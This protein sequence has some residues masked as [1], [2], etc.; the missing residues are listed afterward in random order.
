[1]PG[2]LELEIALRKV[3][4]LGPFAGNV[5]RRSAIP[6]DRLL[7]QGSMAINSQTQW[8]NR[9]AKTQPQKFSLYRYRN[10]KSDPRTG[11]D[12]HSLLVT[13]P[14]L[15]T[16]CS[17]DMSPQGRYFG[18]PSRRNIRSGTAPLV[19]SCN[20]KVQNFPIGKPP[21]RFLT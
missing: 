18:A 15:L 21:K 19:V 2:Q 3:L 17:L 13:V 14:R 12:S 5:C 6:S 4:L 9:M 11:N 10:G 1:M 16:D 7:M 8:P 20:G